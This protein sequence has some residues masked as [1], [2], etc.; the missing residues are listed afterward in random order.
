MG[1]PTCGRHGI[2]V[3]II[4]HCERELFPLRPIDLRNHMPAF[5]A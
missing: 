1:T 4:E 3:G 2:A 5:F